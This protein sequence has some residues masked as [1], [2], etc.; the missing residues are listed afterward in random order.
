MICLSRVLKSDYVIMENRYELHNAPKLTIITKETFRN[1]VPE[2]KLKQLAENADFVINSAL[3]NAEGIRLQAQQEAKK[4]LSEANLVKDNAYYLGFEQGVLEG[5]IKSEQD[6]LE[7]IQQLQEVTRR[8]ENCG[9]DIGKSISDQAVDFAFYL[10]EKIVNL[11]ID[12]SD[13]AFINICKNAAT[14]IGDTSSVTI[15]VGPREYEIVTRYQKEL[16]KCM[17]GLEKLE[18]ELEEDKNGYCI[19][20]T[21]AGSVDASVNSQ[22]N[23]ARQMVKVE[24]EN[25]AYKIK[26]Y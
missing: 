2:K 21:S 22:L 15:K 25:R 12:R 23:R 20:E 13:E 26:D 19:M 9:S 24:A 16:K 7:A 3:K 4:I 11:Q 8:V 17:N 18:I 5:N 6:E 10:A 1:E 14:H